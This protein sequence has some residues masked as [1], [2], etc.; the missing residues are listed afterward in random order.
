MVRGIRLSSHSLAQH[1]GNDSQP[2]SQRSVSSVQE[3]GIDRLRT[4][5]RALDILVKASM[6]DDHLAL[7]ASR[8]LAF[9]ARICKSR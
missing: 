8:R 5:V 7:E 3:A 2:S 1:L 4:S 9:Y 6:G